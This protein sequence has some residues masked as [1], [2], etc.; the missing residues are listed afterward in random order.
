MPHLRPSGDVEP[1]GH[2][3]TPAEGGEPPCAR[4]RPE[5][6][7]GEGPLQ[8]GPLCGGGPRGPPRAGS[9]RPAAGRARKQ[10]VLS[11]KE[12]P[13]L[14]SGYSVGELRA[15]GT[16]HLVGEEEVLIERSP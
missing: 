1:G 16:R 3:Q 6:G 7:G 8:W 14:L 15:A 13:A 5:G 9:P 10:T 12:G 2:A 4:P 11:G